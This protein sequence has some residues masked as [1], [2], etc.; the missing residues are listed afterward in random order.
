MTIADICFNEYVEGKLFVGDEIFSYSENNLCYSNISRKQSIDTQAQIFEHLNV[1]TNKS[2]MVPESL[3]KMYFSKSA[4]VPRYKIRE[5]K[6]KYNLSVIRD[7]KK[8][9]TIVISKNEIN[10]NLDHSWGVYLYERKDV[11]EFLN[12]LYQYNTV[13]SAV[14]L[15]TYAK[16][17]LLDTTKVADSIKKIDAL[18][19][20][21]NFISFNYGD[22]DKF[23][24]IMSRLGCNPISINNVSVLECHVLNN[25]ID[26]KGKKIITDSCLQSILGSSDMEHENYVFVN[27]LL[28]SGDP[29]NIEL[30][31]TLMANCN[32]EGSQHYLLILLNDH[33]SLHRYVKYTHSVAFKSLL[34]FMNFTRYTHHSLDDILTRADSIGKLTDDILKYAHDKALGELERSTIQYKWIKITGITIQKPEQ[35]DD[36]DQGGD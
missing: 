13:T 29:G 27:Q 21:I 7:F 8:A 30:G 4:C 31:L 36:E 16:D 35:E 34:D 18:P 22:K 28:S 15:S 26:S 14:R 11:R 1:Q 17:L 25:L 33:Y 23:E 3:G 19:S 5:I 12:G 20:N 6:D 10:N 32:F 24:D 9:D 2:N